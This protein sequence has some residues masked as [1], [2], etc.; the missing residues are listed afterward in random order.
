MAKQA[1][2]SGWNLNGL[3]I[4]QDEQKDVEEQAKTFA[5]M[6]ADVMNPL[7]A[8]IIAIEKEGIGDNILMF[9]ATLLSLGNRLSDYV[10]KM[11][12]AARDTNNNDK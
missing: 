6:H 5:A 3:E 12:A 11:E 10:N 4:N 1:G 8:R 7:M 2:P 9:A